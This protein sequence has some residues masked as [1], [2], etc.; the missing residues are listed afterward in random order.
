MMRK[1]RIS[2]AAESRSIYAAA[3]PS[4]STAVSRTLKDSHLPNPPR[5]PPAAG[6]VLSSSPYKVPP[7]STRSDFPVQTS[8]YTQHPSSGLP[9]QYSSAQSGFPVQTSPYT[10]H[11]RSGLPVQYPSAP[12]GFP[13]PMP[14]YGQAFG[15]TH[16][17]EGF[18]AEDDD[19]GTDYVDPSQRPRPRP[20]TAERHP[21]IYSEDKVLDIS[22]MSPA[23]VEKIMDQCL[24]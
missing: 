4:S 19:S 5:P 3:P 16:G 2:T 20:G 12:A 17:G 7:S 10:Q 23:D 18:A 8:P 21:E 24:T 9:V 13:A 6:N 15:P 22:E 14:S 11:P 1:F